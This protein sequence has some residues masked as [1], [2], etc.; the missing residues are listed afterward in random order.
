MAPS[1]SEINKEISNL[2]ALAHTKNT[3][4]RTQLFSS[5]TEFLERRHSELSKTEQ[6]LMSEILDKLL[7]NVEM[8]VRRKLADRLATNPDAPPDLIIMLANDQIEVASPVLAL[9][10]LLS[11]DELI[12]VIRHKSAQHQLSIAGRKKLSSAIC[13]ELVTVGNT[14]T[15]V[16]LLNNHDANIDNDTLSAL[17][18][19]SKNNIP[20]QP[21]I[22]ERPDL[23]K[24]LAAKMYQWVSDSLRQSILDNLKLDEKDIDDLLKEAVEDAD[25]GGLDKI[26][27]ERSEVI[28]VN[29]LHKADKLSPAFLMKCLNQGQSS[30]FEIAFSKI[31]NVPRKI[32]RSFLYDRGAEALAVSCCAAGIDQ[33]VFLTIYQLTRTA[34]NLDTRISDDETARA[35]EFFKKLDKKRA[36]MTIQK[37]VAEATGTPIF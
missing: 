28:L 23:P 25:T 8:T 26:T 31:I 17:V 21:P 24:E 1:N 22:I 27:R 13:R 37:W 5:I 14:G 20:I 7:K 19:K 9:S 11:D 29:K 32:M 2:L 12:K 35:F 15:L 36:H 16:V 30:L 33:S 34:R 4:G 6:M 10:K 3:G 18:E